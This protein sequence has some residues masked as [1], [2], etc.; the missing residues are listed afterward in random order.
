MISENEGSGNLAGMLKIVSTKFER[1]CERG[2]GL[3]RTKGLAGKM[4]RRR[5]C[6]IDFGK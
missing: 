3:T 6:M 1:N 2:R 5:S 4:A